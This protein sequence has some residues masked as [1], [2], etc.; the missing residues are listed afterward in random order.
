MRERNKYAREAR[1]EF[2]ESLKSSDVF[3]AAMMIGFIILGNVYRPKTYRQI[4]FGLFLFMLCFF[5]YMLIKNEEN[6]RDPPI[7]KSLEELD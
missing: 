3:L 4:Y 5:I 2:R 6:R 1:R 7:E